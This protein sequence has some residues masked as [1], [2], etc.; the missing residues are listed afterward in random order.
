MAIDYQQFRRALQSPRT[1][2]LSPLEMEE[3]LYPHDFDEELYAEWV[4]EY[5]GIRVAPTLRDVRNA[6]HGFIRDLR[7]AEGPLPRNERLDKAAQ[8]LEE[9]V[10]TLLLSESSDLPERFSIVHSQ[11]ETAVAL[12][13]TQYKVDALDS[14]VSLLF[15]GDVADRHLPWT[16]AADWLDIWISRV[17]A[18]LAVNKPSDEPEEFPYY[19]A[20]VKHFYL[21]ELA[22]E[23]WLIVELDELEHRSRNLHNLYSQVSEL[24]LGYEFSHRDRPAEIEAAIR[25]EIMVGMPR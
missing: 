20:A 14:A 6:A 16:V 25:W 21:G 22:K 15:G 5:M 2:V 1:E 13:D 8:I 10:T 23:N 24:M 4:P 9:I 11:L 18:A 7:F 17:L 3:L 19:S 12:G